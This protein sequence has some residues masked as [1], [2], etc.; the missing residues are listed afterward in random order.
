MLG[1]RVGIQ[2][3]VGVRR[4]R[5]Q[6]WRAASLNTGFSSIFDFGSQTKR[7]VIYVQPPKYYPSNPQ[8]LIRP[9]PRNNQFPRR[10]QFI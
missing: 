3:K 4:N 9:T 6:K 8:N 2:I 10:P 5:L 7:V 1:E